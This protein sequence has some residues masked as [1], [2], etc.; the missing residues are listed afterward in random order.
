[1]RPFKDR[2]AALG[3]LTAV[4]GWISLWRRGLS[5]F[6]RISDMAAIVENERQPDV[7]ARAQSWRIV[8]VALLFLPAVMKP[9]SAFRP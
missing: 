8:T 9:F 5:L 1:L 6:A 3:L 2:C 4:I 7:T